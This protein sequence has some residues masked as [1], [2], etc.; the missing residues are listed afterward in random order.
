MS[1]G[2][3]MERSVEGKCRKDI[4]YCLS[5]CRVQANSALS[6]IQE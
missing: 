1:G 5:S 4:G 2:F 3:D 6:V